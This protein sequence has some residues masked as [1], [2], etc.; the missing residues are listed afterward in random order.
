M[1]NSTKNRKKLSLLEIQTNS[2]VL[3]VFFFLVMFCTIGSAVYIFWIFFNQ[4][5]IE[6]LDI[7]SEN[8]FLNFAKRLGN[9]ILIF[10]N[11]IPISLLVT[12]ETVKFFQAAIIQKREN[13][14][15]NG[16]PCNVQSSNLNEE[17]GQ[18]DFIFS[19]KTGTLTQNQM[20]FKNII[21][22]NKIFPQQ[23][24]PIQALNSTP[25]VD[26]EDE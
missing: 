15:A 14:V 25:F 23:T 16:V 18:I 1:Q 7:K 17:L 10:G 26:F 12:I 24:S 11:F 5:E 19:D 8:P 3:L 2:Y 21:L 6:Y 20:I 13:M 4:D 22:N 9:W